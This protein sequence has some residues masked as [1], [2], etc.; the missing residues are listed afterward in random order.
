MTTNTDICNRSLQVIGTRTTVTDAELAAS[1]TN[2]AIQFN[3]IYANMRDDLLRMA[4]WDCSLKT[5]NLTYITSQTGTP[6]NTSPATQLWQPGQPSPPFAYEYQYPVDCLRACWMI[7]A[8]QTGFAGGVPITTAVTGGASAFWQ[9]PPVKYKVQT[10]EFYPVTSAAVTAGGTGHAVGDIITLPLGPTTSPPIGAPA[11]LLVTG[12]GGGGVITSVSV[13]SVL[14]NSSTPVGGSY[15]AVQANPIAQSSTTGS[16]INA[17][18]TLTQGAKS[19]QR[20]ILT[21]QEFA[22]LVYVKQITAPDVMDTLFQTAWIKLCASAM[23]LALK[24]DKAAANAL[25]QEVN[26]AIQKARSIDGNEG[27]TQNDVTPDWLRIRG[28][29]YNDGYVSGP[30]SGFDWGGVWPSYI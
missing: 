15:F 13:V 16:G 4:P 26:D 11:Q 27:L 25:I 10:D 14:I 9:G 18:F 30:Y 29:C 5:A 21:N 6:E 1:S 20:V 8:N 2:E 22:T 12:V 28:V 17:T 3:L 7:P 19:T 23:L 24:G